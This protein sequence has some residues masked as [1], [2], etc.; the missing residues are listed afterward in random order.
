MAALFRVTFDLGGDIENTIPR[1]FS[2][3]YPVTASLYSSLVIL[4]FSRCRLL[5]SIGASLIGCFASTKIFADDG[6]LFILPQ[7]RPPTPPP[8]PPHFSTQNGSF[9]P[10]KT[11]VYWPQTWEC[12]WTL[13]KANG[14][15]LRCKKI[16]LWQKVSILPA[17]EVPLILNACQSILGGGKCFVVERQDNSRTLRKEAVC[18]GVRGM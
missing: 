2:T 3:I 16:L 13:P 9:F 11:L 5:T 12:G 18:L 7:L 14:T 15:S 17:L 10:Q 1:L 6:G 4:I 8:A